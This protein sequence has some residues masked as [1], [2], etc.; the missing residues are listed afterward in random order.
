MVPCGS[1]LIPED[2]VG[3]IERQV[4]KRSNAERLRV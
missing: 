2:I 4:S 1:F 3:K